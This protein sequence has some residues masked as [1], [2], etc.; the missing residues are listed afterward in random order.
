MGFGHCYISRVNQKISDAKM[1]RALGQLKRKLPGRVLTDL[2]AREQA[3]VDNLRISF[4]PDAVIQV[5]KGAEVGVVLKLA[6]EYGIPVTAR[7]AGS[8]ATGSAVPVRKG[9]VF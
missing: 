5:Q 7:G 2:G 3:S 8:S 1:K 6:N 4:V 9:W